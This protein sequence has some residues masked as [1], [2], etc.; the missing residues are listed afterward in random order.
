M[1]N[2]RD[3]V[4]HNVDHY[5]EHRFGNLKFRKYEKDADCLIIPFQQIAHPSLFEQF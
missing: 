3:S 5:Q 4:M 2:S 1:V